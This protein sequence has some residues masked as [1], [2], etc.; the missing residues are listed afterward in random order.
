MARCCKIEALH[1]GKRSSFATVLIV[2]QKG[3]LRLPFFVANAS[4]LQYKV[5]TASIER[6]KAY[7]KKEADLAPYYDMILES[8]ARVL[9][10]E[11]DFGG[12]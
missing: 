7:L 5:L 10:G 2:K 8:N 1:Y 11:K 9:F 12:K 4:K 3:S 6:L